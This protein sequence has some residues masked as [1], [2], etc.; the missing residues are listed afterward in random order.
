MK[1]TENGCETSGRPYPNEH[2]NFQLFFLIEPKAARQYI[3]VQHHCAIVV[4]VRAFFEG[5]QAMF[6]S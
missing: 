4:A 2:N 5:S 6:Q 1:K 3:P